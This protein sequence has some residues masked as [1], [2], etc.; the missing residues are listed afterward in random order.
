MY[1]SEVRSCTPDFSDNV[2]ETGS[3]IPERRDRR[4]VSTKSFRL[5]IQ[6]RILMLFNG[7]LKSPEV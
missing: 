4:T 5:S 1:A 7:G 6:T 3:N 2:S